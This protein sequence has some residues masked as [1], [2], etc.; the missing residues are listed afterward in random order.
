MMIVERD[1]ESS[2]GLEEARTR[3]FLLDLRELLLVSAVTHSPLESVSPELD[4]DSD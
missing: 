1:R 3:A 2:V 4:E